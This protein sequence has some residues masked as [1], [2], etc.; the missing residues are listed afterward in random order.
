MQYTPEA[1]HT[2][3]VRAFQSL[4]PTLT[5]YARAISGDPKVRVELTSELNSHTDGKV[6]YFRPPSVLGDSFKHVRDN[7]GKRD[8]ESLELVCPECKRRE[9]IL[10]SLY[11][12]MGHIAFNTFAK[13]TPQEVNYLVRTEKM[14]RTGESWPSSTESYIQLARYYNPFLPQLLN[15]LED[16]RVDNQMFHARPGLRPLFQAQVNRIFNHGLEGPDGPIFWNQRPL[17]AQIIVGCLLLGGGYRFEGRLAPEVEVALRDETIVEL[18]RPIA[19]CESASAVYTQSFLILD[20][21]NELG[22]LLSENEEEDESSSDDREDQ[23]EREVGNYDSADKSSSSSSD[24]SD[25]PADG[26]SSSDDGESEGEDGSDEAGNGLEKDDPELDTG[27]DEGNGGIKLDFGTPDDVQ[28]DLDTFN[29]HDEWRAPTD[30]IRESSD[31]D[32]EKMSRAILQGLYFEK[33]PQRVSGV[34]IHYRNKPLFHNDRNLSTAWMSDGVYEKLLSSEFATPIAESVFGPALARMRRVFTENERS[35]FESHLLAGKVNSKVL[36]KRAWNNDPRLFRKKYVPQ[37]KNYSVLLGIDI[38][39]STTGR[40]NA[41]AKRAA[42]A[43]AEL[44]SRMG[45]EF[46][47]YA[48][49]ARK[50]HLGDGFALD[51][52][53]LKSFDEPW[54]ALTQETVM[55]IGSDS[56]NLDGHTIE[57]YRQFISKRGATDKIILYYSDGKMPAANY[58]EELEV[59]K[60][61][62]RTC[63]KQGITLLGVGIRTS[64]PNQ[65]GLNTVQVDDDCD[66][67]RVVEHLEKAILHNR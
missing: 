23:Q 52:Y 62:I 15:A 22:F 63:K 46:A 6:I 16:V 50:H 59:L 7:C 28:D 45:I 33:A 51:V 1:R 8:S 4:L 12:E 38:S 39:G 64:S 10:A 56:E 66:T 37:K 57:L 18:V 67:I 14:K 44:L 20:R 61:E 43:Q 24:D 19:E 34:R 13:P 35:S 48:H 2:A 25:N 27:A 47:V 60:R 26:T 5:G 55:R 65:H 49:T 32:Q 9:H 3:A 58:D 17:N 36:G 30:R 31:V 53:E 21:L 42:F 11:H 54:N 40:N 41:L 29:P